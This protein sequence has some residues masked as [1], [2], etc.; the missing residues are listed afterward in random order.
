M[1]CELVFIWSDEIIAHIAQH[2]VTPDEFEYVVCHP[3]EL[4]ESD[5]SGR[6]LAKGFTETGRW[7]VCIYELE[8]DGIT[9]IPVTAY[10]PTD[11]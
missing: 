2:D 6:P 3:M 4:G 10:E 8:G 11:E 9:V 1:A 5:A 7:L